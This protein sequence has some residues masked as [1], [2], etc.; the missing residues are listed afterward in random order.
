MFAEWMVR[1]LNVFMSS[2]MVPNEW[3]MGCIVPL[4]KG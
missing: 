3:K 2:R 4:Y 1:E